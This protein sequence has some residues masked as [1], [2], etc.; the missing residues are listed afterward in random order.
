MTFR[1]F[2]VIPPGESMS[3]FSPGYTHA[4][5]PPSSE[6]GP[7][8]RKSFAEFFALAKNKIKTIFRQGVYLTEN[9]SQAA[10]VEFV[11]QQRTNSARSRLQKTGGKP[12]RG[13]STSSAPGFFRNPVLFMV[14]VFLYNF[15]KSSHTNV[16]SNFR[17]VNFLI[18]SSQS[19][20]NR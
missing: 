1:I 3:N 14:R 19:P 20:A 2:T 13:F 6:G 12:H 8:R 4:K 18:F 16:F 17:A 5:K 11:R 15:K 7:D 9:T 10:S